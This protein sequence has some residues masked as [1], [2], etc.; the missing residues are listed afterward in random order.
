MQLAAFL[1]RSFN[2]IIKLDYTKELEES[3]D[4]IAD[5]KL[6]KLDF[7]T[8]FYNILEDTIKNTSEIKSASGEK[9]CPKCGAKMILRRSKYGKLFFGCSTWP[10]CNGIA[11]L[12]K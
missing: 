12:D 1:D 11:N 8:K 4:Q 9:I 10:K 7:L 6:S 2:N 5:G 3:L